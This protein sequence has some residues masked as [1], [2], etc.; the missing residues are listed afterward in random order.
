MS[1]ESLRV[2]IDHG[3]RRLSLQRLLQLLQ[4]AASISALLA[5]L[6]LGAHLLWRAVPAAA[7]I[8]VLAVPI[9]VALVIA[10]TRRPALAFVARWLDAELDTQSLFATSL[11]FSGM[12]LSSTACSAAQRAAPAAKT[13]FAAWSQATLPRSRAR[14]QALPALNLRPV[15]SLCVLIAALAGA[16]LALP[17]KTSTP[18]AAERNGAVANQ[19]LAPDILADDRLLI[20]QLRSGDNRGTG[21]SAAAPEASTAPS[22]TAA[23]QNTSEAND[24]EIASPETRRITATGSNAGSAADNAATDGADATPQPARESPAAALQARLRAIAAPRTPAAADGA[25]AATGDALALDATHSGD[26]AA[27]FDRAQAQLAR[28]AH[29]G[30]AARYDASAADPNS[31]ASNRNSDAVAPAPGSGPAEAALM[32]RFIQLRDTEP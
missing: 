32:Q 8:S 23:P 10:A 25:S 29:N 18:G 30:S 20:T 4:R 17:G 7:L 11:E 3:R 22:S 19:T 26:E 27:A 2:L 5:L 14:W 1:A 16:A 6:L 31:S 15:G 9:A 12:E 28:T 21:E 24:A 13:A